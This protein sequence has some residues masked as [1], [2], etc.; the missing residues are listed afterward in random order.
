[1][2]IK[3]IRLETLEKE[4]AELHIPFIFI[5][6]PDSFDALKAVAGEYGLLKEYSSEIYSL[7]TDNELLK[8]RDIFQSVS[9]LV[10]KTLLKS[11]SQICTFEYSH[12]DS[13]TKM[14]KELH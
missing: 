4:I 8:D 13:V 14:A 6:D 5:D 1:M 12:D 9:R 11:G 7:C 3:D 2:D 10:E